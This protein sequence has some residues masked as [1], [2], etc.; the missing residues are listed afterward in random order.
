MASPFVE[1]DVGARIVK[2]TDPD[3]VLFPERVCD[4]GVQPSRA[5]RRA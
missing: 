5:K 1:I 2:V 3:R 4:L